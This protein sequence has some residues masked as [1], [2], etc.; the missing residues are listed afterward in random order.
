[1]G[2]IGE[3]RAV[4][5]LVRISKF[6]SKHLRHDPAGLG[7][8]LEA[9][10]WVAVEVL[11]AAREALTT[12]VTHNKLLTKQVAPLLDVVAAQLTAQ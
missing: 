8:T 5:D 6:L 4:A 9:G 7:L 3:A 12:A 10:G 2:V 11:L 1:M